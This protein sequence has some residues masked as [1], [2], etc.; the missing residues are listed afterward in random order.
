MLTP[1]SPTK[2]MNHRFSVGDW[3]TTTHLHAPVT[4]VVL[5]VSMRITGRI[6]RTADDTTIQV[7]EMQR[8]IIYVVALPNKTSGHETIVF[9][10]DELDAGIPPERYRKVPPYEL[11]PTAAHTRRGSVTPSVSSVPYEPRGDAGGG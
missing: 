11:N 7:P 5:E 8:Y 3:V 6:L 10:E 2:S 9:E 1:P 4:G